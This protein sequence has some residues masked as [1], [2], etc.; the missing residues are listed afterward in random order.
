VFNILARP[1][2]GPSD[3]RVVEVGWLLMAKRTSIIFNAPR[4]LTRNDL[5]P[6]HAK[7]ASYCPAILDH[8]ARIFE[9]ACAY[10]LQLGVRIEG[11]R[12]AISDL[13][14]DMSAVRSHHMQHVFRVTARK[15]WRHP[16][17]P[18]LQFTAPYTFVAD[19]PV[20]VTQMPPFQFYRDPPLPGT[21]ICGRLP[22]HIWPRPLVWAFEWYD[23]KKPLILRRGEP[24]FYLR[25]ETFDPSRPVRIVEAELTPELEAFIDSLTAVTN[26]VRRTFSLFSTA[27]ERRPPKLL[28]K[29]PRGRESSPPTSS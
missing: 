9:V 14:G 11:E 2:N 16:D 4:P 23:T 26:V 7:S 20:Y 15:E 6:K 27:N 3:K 29:R 21:V 22:V 19:E 8:E 25:F 5:P 28:V 1:R 13:S 18:I 12:V 17:R 10:D 24:W